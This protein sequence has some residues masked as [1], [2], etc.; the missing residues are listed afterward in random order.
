[1]IRRPPRST[2]TDTLFPDTT[3][4]R[5]IHRRRPSEQD[6]RHPDDGRGA[7]DREA[8]G[9]RLVQD[10]HARADAEQRHEQ[11]PGHRLVDAIAVEEPVPQSVA[12]ADDDDRLIDRSEENTSE[13]Q[14]LMRTSYA[15]FSLKTK[16]YIN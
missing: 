8:P 9:E 11:R 16:T 4:F 14:S 2:L 13:L 6:D 1:M 7:T 5:S 15:V 3:L 10:D 12:Q